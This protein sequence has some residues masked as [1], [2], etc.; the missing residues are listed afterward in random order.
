MRSLK[1]I[2]RAWK[3][4]RRKHIPV[5]EFI[6]GVQDRWKRELDLKSRQWLQLHPIAVDLLHQMISGQLVSGD[7]EIDYD[8][9]YVFLDNMIFSNT[10]IDRD[11]ITE[12]DAFGKVVNLFSKDYT[13]AGVLISYAFAAYLGENQTQPE[14]T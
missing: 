4:N 2:F 11:S 10:K 3:Y 14:G 9:F 1:N 6:A 13:D 5:E 12:R 7:E 8:V